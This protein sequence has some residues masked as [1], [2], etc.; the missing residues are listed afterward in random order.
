MEDVRLD[1]YLWAV[2]IFKTR[3]DA[4]EG[5][6]APT[7][8]LEGD[9]YAKPSREVKCG[10]RITVRGASRW[11][12]LSGGGARHTSR[13]PAKNVPE[14]CVNVTPQEEL[15]KLDVPRETVFVTRD[16]GTGR[17]DEEGASRTG[18]AHGRDFLRRR[19]VTPRGGVC[20]RPAPVFSGSGAERTHVVRAASSAAGVCPL[21]QADQSRSRSAAGG[22]DQVV[23][24]GFHELR[25]G[26]EPH[27]TPTERMP[28]AAAV[29]MS[30]PESPTKSTRS[31]GTGTRCRISS[32][33][34]GLGF[35]GHAFALAQHGGELHVGKE[36]CDELRGACLE[37]VRGY[38]EPHAPVG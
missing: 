36:A 4:A 12:T 34:A 22:V 18:F 2:R 14:Y 16:R 27:V 25:A 23:G 28:A 3:S 24:A 13:Q 37:L 33:T 8:G 5:G 31:R 10:D 21:R 9:A 20:M 26:A 11:F 15:A 19:G 38:G 7:E 32:A 30:M 6:R 35:Q 1:K 17:P 29:C